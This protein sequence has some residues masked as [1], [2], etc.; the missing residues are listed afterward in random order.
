MAELVI[1]DK[2]REGVVKLLKLSEDSFKEIISAFEGVGPKLFPDELS[3]QVKS[4]V[5]GTSSED[6][7][8]IIAT[9]MSLSSYRAYDESTPDEVA[10]QVVQAAIDADLPVESEKARATFKNRLIK[11]FELNTLLVSAKALGILQANENLFCT[12]RILTDIRPVFGSNPTV[13]PSAA[14]MVHMLDLAYHKK[15]GEVQHVFV[16]MDSLDIETLREALDR[17]DMKAESLKPL[18]KK[19]GV[20]F[21]D[22]SE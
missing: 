6:L 2:Y 9:I 1:P 14:V 12:A 4:K 13:P 16:A 5:K 22:P 10:D 19:A 8:E 15:T 7:S 17:A 20:E 18:I 3:S 21:L 11:F